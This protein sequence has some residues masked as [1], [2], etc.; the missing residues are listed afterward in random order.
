[1]FS[2]NITNGRKKLFD[3]QAYLEIKS[4][5]KHNWWLVFMILCSNTFE[6]FEQFFSIIKRTKILGTIYSLKRW[7]YLI[8][9]QNVLIHIHKGLIYLMSGCCQN[10]Y[11]SGNSKNCCNLKSEFASKHKEIIDTTWII[12]SFK[13]FN[14]SYTKKHRYVH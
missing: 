3:P 2:K 10:C 8:D 12:H 1:M 5:K 4:C 6:F 13:T 7:P 9:F 14:A 11:E